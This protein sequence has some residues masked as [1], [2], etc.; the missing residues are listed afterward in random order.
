M[1]I[2]KFGDAALPKSDYL[3]MCRYIKI[4]NK[5]SNKPAPHAI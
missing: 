2:F 4:V 5:D 3:N 1:K